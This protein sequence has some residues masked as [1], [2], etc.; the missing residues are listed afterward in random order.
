M[1]LPGIDSIPRNSIDPRAVNGAATNETARVR[2]PDHG[3]KLGV[4]GLDQPHE[5]DGSNPSLLLRRA[6]GSVRRSRLLLPAGL[7]CAEPT[8]FDQA[9]G[10]GR[11]ALTFRRL[12]LSRRPSTLTRLDDW[13]CDRRLALPDEIA[14]AAAWHS[15]PR[16]A[17]FPTCKTNAGKRVTRSSGRGSHVS[18]RS[19]GLGSVTSKP[20]TAQPLGCHVAQ[21]GCW[22]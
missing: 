1:R 16:L 17:V 13:R 21:L 10:I 5:T 19:A 3:P 9:D 18:A 6:A 20:S 14:R 11:S 2:C 4:P 15:R 12:L 8:S 22:T 7:A